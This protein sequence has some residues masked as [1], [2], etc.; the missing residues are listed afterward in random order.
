MSGLDLYFWP[1][2]ILFWTLSLLKKQPGADL[3]PLGRE[4]KL[5]KDSS[6]W[7]PE[8]SLNTTFGNQETLLRLLRSKFLNPAK[9]QPRKG[10][11]IFTEVVHSVG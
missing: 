6:W 9:I 1:D 5:H 11:Q 2:G 8:D 4:F 7:P 10:P 3:D